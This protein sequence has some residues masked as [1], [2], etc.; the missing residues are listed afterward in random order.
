[1]ALTVTIGG[2]SYPIIEN[3]GNPEP[4]YTS[5]GTSNSTSSSSGIAGG[6]DSGYQQT[7][8]AQERQRWQCD[9]MDYTGT[10]HFS[11]GEQV[12]ITDPVLG[13]M[14]QGYVN[15][16]KVL[17]IYPSGIIRH[18]LDCV[19]LEWLPSKRTYTRTYSTS[20]LAGKIAVDMLNDVLLDEGVTQNWAEHEDS[21]TADFNTGILSG[22]Q[23]VTDAN[24]NQWLEL[25]QAGQNTVITENTTALFSTGTLTNVQ[26]VNNQ[27]LPTT[28]SGLK[29]QATLPID[30]TTAFLQLLIWS[31]S[32]TLG[33][34]DFFNYAIF[35]SSTSPAYNATMSMLFSD[36]TS[37]STAGVDQNSYSVYSGTDLTNVAKDR[38]YTR[39]ISLSAYSGKTVSSIILALRGMKAG[40]YTLYYQNAYLDSGTVFFSTTAT[41]TQVNPIQVQYITNY[42]P[43][44]VITSVIPVI[45]PSTSSRI[46]P[47]YNIDPVKLVS[48][49]SVS[50]VSGGSNGASGEVFASYDGGVTYIQ[51]SNNAALPALPGGSNVAGATLTLKETFTLGSNP[52]VIPSL[53]NV[54]VAIYSAPAA[55]K[56]DSITP[57]ATQAEWNTGTFT[58][59]VAS[60]SG[61]LT[62]GTITS[63]WLNNSIANQ[64]FFHAPANSSTI[65]NSISSNTYNA[66]VKVTNN[67]NQ[68]GIG[69]LD[70]AG[71]IATT[72][73]ISLEFDVTVPS[74]NNFS[75]QMYICYLQTYWYDSSGI[76]TD[77]NAYTFTFQQA[78][79]SS[80]CVLYKGSN[81]SNSGGSSTA[82]ATATVG[83]N[84]THVKITVSNAGVHTIYLNGS[85]TPTLT[86]TDTTYTSGQI[87]VGG[88]TFFQSSGSGQTAH[89]QFSNAAIT[90]N[91]TTNGTW[92]GPA[93]SISSLGTIDNSVIYWTEL[94][95]G[96]N[97][98][99]AYVQTSVDGGT[100]YQTCT[101]GGIIPGLTAG[102]NVSGKSVQVYIWMVNSVANLPL[103]IIRQLSWRVL[104]QYPG[105]SGTRSTVPLGNDTSITRTVGSGWGTAY[106]SQAWS[107]TGTGTTAVA[108]GEETITNTTGDVHMHLGTRT[109]TDEDGTVRFQ[110][111]AATIVA[112]IELRYTDANNFYRLQVSTTAV[113]II[114]VQ[115]GV[116]V[117]LTSVSMT[118]LT[119]VW[120]RARFRVV[121]ATQ[122]QLFGNVWSDGSLEPTIN[123]TTGQWDNS[124]WT[125]AIV[126]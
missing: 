1:M 45:N 6:S 85:G 34:S 87:G 86:A 105:S 41:T 12:V 98:A 94:N 29:L 96:S 106:D 82:L 43:A 54:Q 10:A 88:L 125:I 39:R 99:A 63:P 112:G 122:P 80:N 64:I 121:G 50:W 118:L 49:S 123:A 30:Q 72:N 70:W 2:V 107:Q 83:S 115:S 40:S 76:G 9:I 97:I 113:S 20:Q 111:S 95:M 55:T 53:S 33:S 42:A 79:I 101:S 15:S 22:T 104:G 69:R 81:S 36:G 14:F 57:F 32:V 74:T 91:T 75:S 38:W 124:L 47:N 18:S 120:Y 23:G 17:P 102:T 119:G 26:A 7:N 8:N 44:S 77:V 11:K 67:Q 78:G 21:T 60:A 61:D 103:P 37:L 3:N 126:D 89:F 19:G 66:N 73:G 68:V 51:C 110:L 58:G 93:T 71:T 13:I 92:L 116:S 31:G 35:I 90:P 109:S 48:S 27:L 28:V 25:A 46:S 4:G 84:P 65:T 16:D 108:A 24:G 114:K 62:M 59:L 117:T 56:S 5:G 52:E 100:S